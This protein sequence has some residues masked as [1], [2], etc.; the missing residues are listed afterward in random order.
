LFKN[1]ALVEGW[2][3]AA[4]SRICKRLRRPGIDSEESIPPACVA[5]RA[6]TTNRVVVTGP[7][8]SESIPGLLKRFKNTGSG[9]SA[10]APIIREEFF[11]LFGQIAPGM[12]GEKNVSDRLDHKVL[13]YVEYRA[14][15]G[16]FQ[17]VDPPPPL[18]PASVY[19]PASP[20]V[21]GEDTL[22]GW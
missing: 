3:Q 22:A 15:S 16:V 11:L 20:L 13:T 10:R 7:P 5:W 2:Y 14:V 21:L 8:G 19:P 9:A 1:P 18:R 12:V 17:N 4:K 6:S